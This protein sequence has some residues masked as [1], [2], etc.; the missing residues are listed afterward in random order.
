MNGQ[1]IPGQFGTSAATFPNVV[2]P[3][4]QVWAGIVAGGRVVVDYLN[5]A[6]QAVNLDTVVDAVPI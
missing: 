3:D 2:K 5:D 4:D 1:D 6:D